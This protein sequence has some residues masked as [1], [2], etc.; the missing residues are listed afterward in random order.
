MLGFLHPLLDSLGLEPLLHEFV[1]EANRPVRSDLAVPS[2]AR[3]RAAICGVPDDSSRGGAIIGVVRDAQDRAPLAGVAVTAEWLELSLGRE[4]MTGR[5]SSQVD[6]T[7]ENGWYAVCNVPSPGTLVI[8]AVRGA[9]STDRVEVDLSIGAFARRELYI[10]AARTV[11]AADSVTRLQRAGDGQL[12]GVVVAAGS[13]RPLAGAQV[14]VVDG[15]WTTA[16]NRGEWTLD[17]APTGT[18]VLQVRAVGYYPQ[19]VIVDVVNGAQPVT[20]ALP[21]MQSVLDTVRVSAAKLTRVSRGFEERRL[22]A[23]GK[24][25]TQEDVIRRHPL[26]TSDLFHTVAGL[27]VEQASDAVDGKRILMKG[28]FVDRCYPAIYIDGMY[29]SDLSADDIDGMVRP[30]EVAGIEVY[31]SA[32]APAQFSRGMAGIGRTGELCGSIVIWTRPSPARQKRLPWW[33]RTLTLLGAGAVA[34]LIGTTA[35]HW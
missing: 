6:T 32:W 7:R 13:R 30:D 29:M 9:A 2:P 22:S 11:V 20:T 17:T 15:A 24:F 27:Q 31:A 16:N 19:R 14:G 26:V 25:L 35:N 12:R 33:Q 34:V 5:I 1:V 21:T 28:L 3:M 10:G 18:R 4:G 23:N 8:S